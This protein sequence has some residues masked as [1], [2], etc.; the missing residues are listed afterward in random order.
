MKNSVFIAT[1]LDGFIS[2]KEGKI[3]FLHSFPNPDN[4]DLGYSEFMKGVDGIIMGRT[5]FETV[6]SFDIEWPYK[7][8]V[9]V[10]SNTLKNIPSQITGVVKIVNGNLT[11]IILNLN[12]QGYRNLY[13]DGGKTIQN[14]LGE[15]LIDEIT[16]TTIPIILG[17][18]TSLFGNL[19]S[20]INFRCINS[21][22]YLKSI[23]QNKF[24]RLRI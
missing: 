23:V 4:E 13:I 21:T 16:I 15:D 17:G 9:F 20:P 24:S 2:D 10:L 12:N 18:G 8:P 5:T 11:E 3:D 1:S 6:C 19:T 14:F 22:I 7:V